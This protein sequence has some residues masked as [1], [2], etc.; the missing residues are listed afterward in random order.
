MKIEMYTK[1]ICSYCVKAKALFQSKNLTFV[2]YNIESD[3]NKLK[4]MLAKSNGRKTVPQI[5]INDTHIGGYDDLVIFV[6]N[7]SLDKLS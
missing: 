5:F 7:G 3:I 2:E 6:Q 1:N 4:E